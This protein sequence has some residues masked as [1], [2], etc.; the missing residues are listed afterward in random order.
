MPSSPIPSKSTTRDQPV[1]ILYAISHHIQAK[2]LGSAG[3]VIHL[4]LNQGKKGTDGEREECEGLEERK[5][6]RWPEVM[7]ASGADEC[8]GERPDHRR[9]REVEEKESA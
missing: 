5:W 1:C 6:Q 2:D 4:A 9:R 7:G 8:H 3:G